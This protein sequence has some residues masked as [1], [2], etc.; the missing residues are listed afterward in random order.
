MPTATSCKSRCE[1]LPGFSFSTVKTSVRHPVR[2]ITVRYPIFR[3]GINS[4]GQTAMVTLG[5]LRESPYPGTG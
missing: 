1:F 2:V 4:S 3:R 5:Y